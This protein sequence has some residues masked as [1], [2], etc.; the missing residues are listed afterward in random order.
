MPS[1]RAV[2]P[3]RKRTAT[4]DGTADAITASSN[5]KKLNNTGF[6]LIYIGFTLIYID[7]QW[8]TYYISTLNAFNISLK[9]QLNKSYENQKP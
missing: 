6:T 5:Y 3:A 2:Q 4:Q 9:N 8:Y 7:L 1:H